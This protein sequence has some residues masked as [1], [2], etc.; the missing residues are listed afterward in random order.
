MYLLKSLKRFQVHPDVEWKWW[1]LQKY[2]WDGKT[3]LSH[4]VWTLR[5]WDGDVL[6]YP[7]SKWNRKVQDTKVTGPFRNAQDRV[8]DK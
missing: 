1:K 3:V 5:T 2:S 4:R 8:T 7:V 6:S